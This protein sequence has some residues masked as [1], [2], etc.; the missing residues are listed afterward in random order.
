M[1]EMHEM[2][3]SKRFDRYYELGQQAFGK[4]GGLWIVVPLQLMVNVGG[5]IVYMVTGG[6]SLKKFHDIICLHNNCSDIRLTYFILISGSVHFILSQL[7]N[8]NSVTGIS[9][10]AAIMSL[11]YSL[12]A[13]ITSAHNGV[14]PGVVYTSPGKTRADNVFGFMAALGNIAFAYAGHCVALEIQ[15]TI[16]STPEKPSKKSMWKGVLIAYIIVGLCYFP[17]AFIG[18]WAFGNR[19]EDDILI[20]LEKPA[21]LIAA[22]NL[23]V[24]IH[25]IGSYQVFAMPVFDMMESVLVQKFNLQ[26]TRKLRL[27]VR[28]VYVAL[29]LFLS[30]AFPF[31][32]A[33]LSFFGGFALAPTSYYLPC[34]MWLLLKKPNKFSLSWFASWFCVAFGVLLM[35]LAPIGA[36]RQIITTISTYKFFS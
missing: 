18:Y 24:V 11:G 9:I 4:K 31:F 22:A 36:L 35:I 15:A 5:N 23:F 33:L 26:L 12:I 3:P 28:S 29:T 1:T 7:P 8:F 19:V 30:M 34:I 13:W 14:K 2:I 27:C 16:P 21:W 6:K 20:S 32:G 17:V 25:V 10:A